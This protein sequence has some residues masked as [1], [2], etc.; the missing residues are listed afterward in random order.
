MY[1]SPCPTCLPGKMLSFM[2]ADVSYVSKCTF[3]GMSISD[4]DITDR[5]IQ[6]SAQCFYRKAN[7]VLS[8]FKSLTRDTKS[9]LLSSYC[10]DAYG[11]QLWPFYDKS[12]SHFF[13]GNS[14]STFGA[15]NRYLF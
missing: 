9:K 11:S 6:R 15:N 10:L 8:D 12:E 13:I 4:N 5:Y 2:N 3:L 14:Y 7:E 1:F